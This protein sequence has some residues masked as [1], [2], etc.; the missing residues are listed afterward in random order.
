MKQNI[1][2]IHSKILL[3]S[4][5]LF[6]KY[7]SIKYFLLFFHIFEEKYNRKNANNFDDNKSEQ[8]IY[9]CFYA[10]PYEI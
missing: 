2:S 9:K 4:L 7:Y 1:L 10:L 3:N 8:K 6:P 5:H